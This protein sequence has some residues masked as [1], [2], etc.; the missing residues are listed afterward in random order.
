MKSPSSLQ[1]RLRAARLAS[2]VGLALAVLLVL[3]VGQRASRS[4]FDK[5]RLF[6][7]A[8]ERFDVT[9]VFVAPMAHVCP[10]AASD[11]SI[12][13][14]EECLPEIKLGSESSRALFR[15]LRLPTHSEL[16]AGS[17]PSFLR[18]L[19]K[20]NL[21]DLEALFKDKDPYVIGFRLPRESFSDNVIGVEPNVLVMA[22]AQDARVCFDHRCPY[23]MTRFAQNALAFPL[24]TTESPGEWRFPSGYVDVFL[25]GRDFFHPIGPLLTD[26]LF[27]TPIS[28]THLLN[29]FYSMHNYG[30]AVITAVLFIALFL[31]AFGFAAV[32][33]EFPD[34]SAFCFLAASFAF[35]AICLDFRLI[36]V[37]Q[38][39]LWYGVMGWSQIN[40]LAAAIGFAL[41]TN[42][43]SG[44]TLI[45]VMLGIG[46]CGALAVFAT[47]PRSGQTAGLEW[48]KAASAVT[49]ILMLTIPPGL[50][51]QGA[52]RCF[53][54]YRRSLGS[55]PLS[56][57]LDFRRRTFEQSAYAFVLLAIAWQFAGE[58]YQ[59]V[60]QKILLGHYAPTTGVLLF[61]AFIVLLYHSTTKMAKTHFRVDGRSEAV[62]LKARLPSSA[63]MNWLAEARQGIMLQVDLRNSSIA[64]GSLKS[65]IHVLMNRLCE[66]MRKSHERLGYHWMIAK[67][68]GDEWIVILSRKHEHLKDE[69]TELAIATTRDAV[70][71][72]EIVRAMAPECS[73]HVNLFALGAY[74]LSSGRAAAV[75]T[76]ED[77]EGESGDGGWDVIDFAS[78]E[79]NYLMKWAGKSRHKDC[80]TVGAATP[81]I[82]VV[83]GAAALDVEKVSRIIVQHDPSSKDA[84]LEAEAL[85]LQ[86]LSMPWEGP[87]AMTMPPVLKLARVPEDQAS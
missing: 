5:A 78:R 83:L 73:I 75:D 24:V 32:W 60:L 3:V 14:I 20:A 84:A 45:A 47:L 39:E 76:E 6:P 70:S 35:Y 33:S 49:A 71:W 29:R 36:D 7:T 62:K 10:R 72:R 64:A 17:D 34:Y 30:K 43:T 79:A 80:V 67:K 48:Y 77:D 57:Q 61:G 38:V 41:A 8:E 15:P 21:P 1:D 13:A 42:R 53:R 9:T 18:L 46:A 59:L 63:Y 22:G 40:L 66:A 74:T 87:A 69:L 19:G 86:V 2:R 37:R 11:L 65:R 12:Q 85:G 23:V 25:F 58:I 81:Y 4:L 27:V 54:A 52:V 68:N 31:M 55:G 44:R 16:L 50:V 28:K 82:D 51:V 26:G 56:L